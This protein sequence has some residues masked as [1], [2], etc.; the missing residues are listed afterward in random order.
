MALWLAAPLAIL[1][2]EPH[3]L[4][5]AECEFNVNRLVPA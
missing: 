4:A 5:G 3:N 1:G 2:Q